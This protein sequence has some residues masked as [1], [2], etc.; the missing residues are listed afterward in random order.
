MYSLQK[1]NTTYLNIP[2]PEALL[3]G[4]TELSDMT[5]SLTQNLKA[6]GLS[7]ARPDSKLYFLGQP[8]TL[9]VYPTCTGQAQET[10]FLVGEMNYSA[11]DKSTV[12]HGQQYCSIAEVCAAV[13]V[14]EYFE[15]ARRTPCAA[16]PDTG[17]F[18]RWVDP[19]RRERRHFA[20]PSQCRRQ[21]QRRLRHSR[22]I[23]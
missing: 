3:L 10:P 4:S 15:E 12:A 1:Y 23:F 13:P 9:W 22:R 2:K 18:L 17:R 6:N 7:A 11:P 5:L 8:P 14:E 21:T 16:T 20:S 19:E